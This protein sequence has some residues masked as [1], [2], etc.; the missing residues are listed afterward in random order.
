MKNEK[1]TIMAAG[2]VI[3]LIAAAL[4]FFREPC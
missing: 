4:V 3:G 2:V 1:T